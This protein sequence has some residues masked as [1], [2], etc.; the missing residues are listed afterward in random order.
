MHHQASNDEPD[1]SI[2]A[3]PAVSASCE[4]ENLRPKTDF[5]ILDGDLT[6][7]DKWQTLTLFL[8]IVVFLISILSESNYFFS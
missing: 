8:V 3:K 5:F 4:L 6:F 1:P 7:K 2:T